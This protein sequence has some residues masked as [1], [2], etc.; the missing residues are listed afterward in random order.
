M[1][2]FHAHILPGADHGSD[3][4]KT[5]LRQLEL[6]EQAGIHRI[7]ATPHFYPQSDDIGEFLARR[8][9]TC[10][11]LTEA[12]RGSVRILLGAEVHLCVGLDHLK[13]LDQLC[14]RG[15]DTILLELPF[16]GYQSGLTETF[17]R[18]LESG[19]FNPVLAHVDRYD[20]ELMNRLFQL[21]LSGQLNSEPFTRLLGRHRLTRW[22]D[23]G[24]IVALGSDI[25]GTQIG[26][27]Q[28]LKAVRYLD[29]RAAVIED[30]VAEYLDGAV[31]MN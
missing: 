24:A 2:D 20:A 9:R 25:H 17:Q 31:A 16:H 27:T 21:G 6:A 4:L 15:T 3:G 19:R 13:Q 29:R 5:S 26:Y 22:I 8:E 28:Y 11:E 14:I 1:T 12:Y 7:V 10:R 30:R 23:E 18:L